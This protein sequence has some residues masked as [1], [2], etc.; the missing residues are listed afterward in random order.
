[1]K[2][3]GE[4]EYLKGTGT[5]ALDAPADVTLFSPQEVRV[6][7][8]QLVPLLPKTFTSLDAVLSL[9]LKNFIFGIGDVNQPPAFQRGNADHD[10]LLHFYWQDTWKLRP[11]FSLNYGL[12]W[13]FETNALNHD[14]TKPPFLAPI[15]GQE[16][17]GPEKHAWL[18]FSPALGFAWSLPDEKTVVRGGGGIFYDTL[19]IENR[20]VERAY[21]GPLGTGYLPLPSSIVPNPIP[22]IPGVP[23]GQPLDFHVPTAFSGKAVAAILP[24]LR[25]A[26]IQQLH[27]NPDNTDLAVRNIHVFKASTDLFARDFVPASAQHL[28][29][30]VQHQFAAST[31]V[32][33]DLVY[34]H[35][36]HQMLRGID[37][38]H[39]DAVNGPLI[40]A[41]GPSVSTTP[42]IE[43]SNGPIGVSISGGRS[44]YKGLLVR[45]E[46]RFQR[47]V[48]AQ[49][50]Y[51]LQAQTGIYG[52]YD[53][54]TPIT[55]LNNWFQNVG[56]QLPRHVF[57]VS[58]MI[59]LPAGF[60]V[61]F[62]SAF[63][64]RAPFQPVITGVDLYGTGIDAF[65]LPGSGTNQFNFGL[66]RSDLAQ[67]VERYN[68]NYAGKPGP[69]PTQRFPV[70]AL[71]QT[72]NF[73]RV[74]NS[75][76]VRVTKLIRLG[77]RIE[78][79]I[80]GEVFNL[81]NFANLTAYG[82][83]LLDPGFG[84]PTARTGNAFGSGGTRAFQVGTRLSF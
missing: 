20:L 29:F 16:G 67:L 5:Y 51:A 39:Y 9:P 11:R 42:G 65:L 61:S 82:S 2:F 21:L 13:S 57:N 75:Q 76:D 73:G 45:A 26:A 24:F 33:A 10:H 78:W 27:V 25:T 72:F 15:F 58:G 28:S 56:P 41:C 64:S 17:L 54:Y 47:R 1:M 50:S 49:L 12:A 36:V 19:N 38:N 74:F 32:T 22:F 3:G 83:N 31:V 44:T 81:L 37:L 35:A 68:Q 71:P 23:I 30:G 84:Q 55:N 40:P 46:R 59:D 14:L 52:M 79:R 6:L 7:T 63:S 8:P 53:L 48:Q 62:I 60:Q 69:D 34:R 43:C 70:I 4:W 80:L 66:G 18:H 77:E